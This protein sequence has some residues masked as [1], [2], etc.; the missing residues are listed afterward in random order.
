[1]KTI[2]GI[3]TDDALI[4]KMTIE[5]IKIT[6]PAYGFIGLSIVTLS[7]LQGMGR[8]IPHL[9]I[10]IFRLFVLKIPLSYIF[11]VLMSF[12]TIGIWTGSAIS[13][14]IAGIGSLIWFY[15]TSKTPE[16]YQ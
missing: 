4:L 11:S 3:F 6:A 13:I 9:L 5:Y 10:T 8:G 12:G 16:M 7:G 15:R 1:S 2:A 14:I